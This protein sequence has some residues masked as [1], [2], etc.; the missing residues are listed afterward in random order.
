[1]DPEVYC[2]KCGRTRDCLKH[3]R[4]EF[5]PDAAKKW[6]RKAHKPCDGEIRYRAGLRMGGPVRGI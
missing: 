1:M 3:L 2:V 6:L 5:P 4:A